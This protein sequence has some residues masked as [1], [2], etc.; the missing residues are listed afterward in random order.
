MTVK[1]VFSGNTSNRAFTL[2]EIMI[3]VVIVGVLAAVITPRLTGR[4]EAARTNVARADIDLYIAT[5]LKLYRIDN[6]AYPT[7]EEGLDALLKAPPSAAN[8]KGPYLDRKVEDPWG[9]PYRYV[10]PG[11]QHPGWYDLSSPGEEG[12]PG[13]MSGK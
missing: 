1:T 8:W 2:V 11:A 12:S 9:R 7:T 13:I 6:G 5:A 10:S 3:V 4:S